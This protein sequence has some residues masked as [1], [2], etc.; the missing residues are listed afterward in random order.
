MRRAD[1]SWR[2][3]SRLRFWRHD[4][5]RAAWQMAHPSASRTRAVPFYGCARERHRLARRYRASADA[6]RGAML[7]R[8]LGRPCRHPDAGRFAPG[9]QRD[10]DGGRHGHRR[11]LPQCRARRQARLSQ[12]FKIVGVLAGLRRRC[13]HR[14]R[15]SA[16]AYWMLG[17]GNLGQAALWTIG[18]PV[19]RYGHGLPVSSGRGQVR[20]RQSRHPVVDQAGLDGPQKGSR[21]GVVGGGAWLR[22]T[23]IES[24]FAD[25]IKRSA[26]E[27]GLAIVGV[28][29]L[30]AGRAAAGSNFDLVLDA[31]LGASPSEIFDSAPWLPRRALARAGVASAGRSL[32][33]Y[34]CPGA[35]GAR[36]RRSHRSLRGVDDRRPQ[37]RR[38]LDGGRRSRDP[39]GTSLPGRQRRHLRRSRRRGVDE[40]SSRCRPPADAGQTRDPSV[41]TDQ[42]GRAAI[43][44]A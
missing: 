42:A 31:G 6:G 14:S 22:H 44:E 15:L 28:D 27:P 36:R 24:R 13:R 41:R 3:L 21:R 40:L 26:D 8:W 35:P 30:A 23:V 19:C 5:C 38:A 11:G 7:G 33:S 18:L 29:N 10:R 1:V 2:R 9:R 37:S 43:G 4:R 20:S 39:G 16:R 25:G 34:A 12:G 17:L 32:G